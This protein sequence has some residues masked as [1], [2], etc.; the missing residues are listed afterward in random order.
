MYIYVLYRRL[1]NK[2]IKRQELHRLGVAQLVMSVLIRASIQKV[3]SSDVTNYRILSNFRALTCW[4]GIQ[5]DPSMKEVRSKSPSTREISTY[6]CSEK[7]S[8]VKKHKNTRIIINFT[9]VK[10]TIGKMNKIMI[11]KII[12]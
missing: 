11:C 4:S 12:V 3:L 2:N 5:K 8:V 7:S 6:E 10:I 1:S 9:Y